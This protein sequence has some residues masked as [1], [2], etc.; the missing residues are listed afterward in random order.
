[1]DEDIVLRR[2][3]KISPVAAVDSVKT[4]QLKQNPIRS[5][6]TQRASSYIN[7]LLQIQPQA[8]QIDSRLHLPKDPFKSIDRLAWCIH[9]H[10]WEAA[11]EAAVVL[12]LHS[13]GESH[14][15]KASDEIRWHF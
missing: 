14:S 4:R 3:L 8:S 1:M 11:E 5:K 7:L 12:M 6:C 2:R 13:Q 9:T 10:C 15:I